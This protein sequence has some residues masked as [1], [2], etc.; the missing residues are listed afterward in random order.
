MPHVAFLGRIQVHPW[1]TSSNPAD[2]L[3][4]L[5]DG[6]PRSASNIVDTTRDP[7]CRRGDGR[8]HRI[9]HKREVP[10][11]FAVTVHG[12]RLSPNRRPKKPVEAH[13]RPLPGAIHRE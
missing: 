5:V 9:S 11:L 4:H 3:E 7:A 1:L 12:N 6:N 13:I 10:G 8:T 2:H